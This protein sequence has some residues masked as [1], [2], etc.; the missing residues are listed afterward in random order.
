MASILNFPAERMERTNARTFILPDDE[1]AAIDFAHVLRR[2]EE[3]VR[4]KQ[5][6][7]GPA[8]V[9]DLTSYRGAY[10]PEASKG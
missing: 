8:N 2:L 9:I 6:A 10:V 4:A 7:E 1:N 5:R 3:I